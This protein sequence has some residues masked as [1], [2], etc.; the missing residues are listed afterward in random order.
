[1]GGELRHYLASDDQRPWF[2]HTNHREVREDCATRDFFA[3]GPLCW[4]PYG[5]VTVLLSI[6][7]LKRQSRLLRV[8]G[9]CA[10]EPLKTT[11]A[12]IMT[13]YQTI[14]TP[15]KLLLR[16][17]IPTTTILLAVFTSY[18]IRKVLLP[19]FGQL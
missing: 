11:S 18:M 8:D 5:L 1:V 16:C 9:D 6:L 19:C 4:F 3:L 2:R 12:N 10:A 15:R 7:R 13:S 14:S 17:S